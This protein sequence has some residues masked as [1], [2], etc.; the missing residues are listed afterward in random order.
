M[1]L[2]PH[3]AG[4]IGGWH[5]AFERIAANLSRVEAVRAPVTW[6]IVPA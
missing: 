1:V 3:N 5:D 2:T 6:G 4:G